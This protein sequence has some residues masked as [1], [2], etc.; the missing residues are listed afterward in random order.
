M[1]I[2]IEPIGPQ[3][4]EEKARLHSALWRSTYAGML[5]QEVL[6]AVTPGFALE[7]TRRHA[8]EPDTAQFVALED[9]GA[10]NRHV[11]GFAEV[12]RQARPPLDR[13]GAPELTFLYVDAGH[14]RQG[15]ARRLVEAAQ[16]AM[17]GPRLVLWVFDGNEP[18]TT[19]Y[20][21]MGFHFTGET[22]AEDDGTNRES[23]MAN[24]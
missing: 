13:H 22:Q 19:C 16:E 6:D 5:P 1:T 21:A 23:A 4:Y 10:G 15:I 14:R 20:H 24:F 11:V 2:R 17:G 12:M 18:A 7:V 8:A 3:W 9:D